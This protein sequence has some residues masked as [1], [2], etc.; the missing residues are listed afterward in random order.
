MALILVHLYF[1]LLGNCQNLKSSRYLLLSITKC[2]TLIHLRQSL[3]YH[4]Y[5]KACF[6][7][8]RGD[9][10]DTDDKCQNCWNTNKTKHYFYLG[11]QCVYILQVK[12]VK[13]NNANNKTV[14][15]LNK[16]M[17]SF[18]KRIIWSFLNIFLTLNK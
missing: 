13:K 12:T 17:F 6:D 15:M 18:L 10:S 14:K 16:N 2:K 5:F 3:Q 4:I 9:N 7:Q 11:Y 1:Q 8:I